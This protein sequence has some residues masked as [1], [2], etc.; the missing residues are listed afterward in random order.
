MSTGHKGRIGGWLRYRLPDLS[1]EA[2][3]FAT[4]GT[5]AY[6]ADTVLF[7]VAHYGWGMNTL[8][9]KILSTVVTAT[10][11]F[12]GNRQWTWRYRPRR[13]LRGEYVRY[14]GFNTVGLA[15]TLVSVWLYEVSVARWPD[16]LDNP[17]ALN[18]IVNVFGVGVASLFRFY[19]YRTWVFHEDG[20]P[21]RRDG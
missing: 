14:F 6:I 16:L 9:A 4:V 5:I 20:P 19:A 17:I 7:N 10:L 1:R 11:A 18:L 12:V 2:G 3:K 8:S 15:I 21:G 13:G